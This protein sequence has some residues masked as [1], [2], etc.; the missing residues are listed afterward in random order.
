MNL[1][2]KMQSADIFKRNVIKAKEKQQLKD[3]QLSSLAGVEGYELTKSYIGKILKDGSR[4]NVTLDKLDA[5]AAAL[6]QPA[7][8][9]ISDTSTI[10]TVNPILLQDAVLNVEE[11]FNEL[12]IEDIHLKCSAIAVVYECLISDKDPNLELMR[13]LRR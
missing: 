13:L 11:V 2:A 7:S 8:A 5:F 3:A 6:N 12:E 1:R 9:L 4:A 10:N